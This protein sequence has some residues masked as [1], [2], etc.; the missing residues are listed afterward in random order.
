LW[1]IDWDVIRE[2]DAPRA[3]PLSEFP[4]SRRDIAVVVP[5]RV[6]AA[7]LMACAQAAGDHLLQ[8]VLIFD[9]YRGKGLPEACKSVAFGLIFNDYSRTLTQD[10]IDA[11]M[12]KIVTRLTQELDAQLRQ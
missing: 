6:T 11:A 7:Q 4:S 3:E 5:E 10:E 12:A 9:L 2:I 1:D 8:K